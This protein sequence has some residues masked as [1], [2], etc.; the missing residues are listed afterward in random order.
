M[1]NRLTALDRPTNFERT[2]LQRFFRSKQPLVLQEGYIGNT[3][4]LVTLKA[5][6]DDTWLDRQILGLLVRV[7]NRFLSVCLT[8]RIVSLVV[9]LNPAKRLDHLPIVAVLERGKSAILKIIGVEHYLT[10]SQRQST[11]GSS[12]VLYSLVRV[13]FFVMSILIVTMLFLLSAPLV[14]L[15]E[16]SQAGIDG[17]VL[18]KMMGFRVCCILLFGGVLALCT[19]AKKHEIYGACAA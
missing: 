5:D 3:G 18:A 6:R 8:Q 7:N 13:H 12:I 19:R 15:Y 2:N 1:S 9:S 14:P 4:D 10:H 17:K 11:S 16:W